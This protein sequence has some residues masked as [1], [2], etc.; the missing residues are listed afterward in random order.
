MKKKGK[1][2]RRRQFI[3]E[4]ARNDLRK[5]V[6]N[7]TKKGL[8]TCPSPH[9][10]IHYCC[11]YTSALSPASD[12]TITIVVCFH[13]LSFPTL[14]LTSRPPLWLSANMYRF[15]S[16]TLSLSWQQSATPLVNSY[17]YCTISI[18]GVHVLTQ[19]GW[20]V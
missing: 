18:V 10:M 9:P 12:V 3:F 4:V 17:C 15:T 20:L 8:N 19:V 1:K 6:K 2:K 13:H 11:G 14:S 16:L 5:L 7:T